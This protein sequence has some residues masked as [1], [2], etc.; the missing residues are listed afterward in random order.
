MYPG[1][2]MTDRDIFC[3]VSHLLCLKRRKSMVFRV[4]DEMVTKRLKTVTK[5]VTKGQKCTIW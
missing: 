1:P 5:I 4:G 2:D 3:I